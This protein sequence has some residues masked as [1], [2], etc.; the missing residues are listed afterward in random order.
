MGPV[1]L[2]Q[3]HEKLTYVSCV[4]EEDRQNFLRLDP[5][6]QIGVEGD[7]RFDQVIQRVGENRPVKTAVEK[8]APCFVVGS[9]W[10]EDEAIILPALTH[11][12]EQGLKVILAP[13]EPTPSHLRDLEEKLSGLSIKSHRYSMLEDH[14]NA[15]VVI[16]DQVGVLADLYRLGSVAFVGAL[17]LVGPYHHNSREALALKN[18]GFA[19]EIANSQDLNEI[20]MGEMN[21]TPQEGHG[22]KQAILEF[23]ASNRGVSHKVAQWILREAKI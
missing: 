13:H 2:R 4:T 5:S 20:L 17:S 22:R 19:R 11:P 23:V 16:V 10:P 7:T 21:K 1:L 3:Y 8:M 12:V 15:P 14:L 9:S 6:L 18:H